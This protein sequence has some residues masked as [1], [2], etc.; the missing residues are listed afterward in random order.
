MAAA[1]ADFR[2][3]SELDDK[4]KKEGREGLSLELAPTGDVLTGL[5][6]K[7][8]SG[9]VLVG[10]AAE[11]GDGGVGR[12]RDKLLRK[13]LDAV[14]LNDISRGDIGFDAADNE[15][16]IVTAADEHPV[17][18]APKEDVARAIPDQV[19]AIRAGGAAQSEEV[20]PA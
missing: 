14:V 17:P 6:E 3:A 10:F 4:I 8:R 16:T 9:Q 13:R 2:P 15:V 19:E 12:A 11:H 1:V 5:A 20:K 18:L 7:R